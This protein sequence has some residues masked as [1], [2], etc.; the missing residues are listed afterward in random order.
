[1]S[2]GFSLIIYTLLLFLLIFSS[3]ERNDYE[4]FD[5]DTAGTWTLYTTKDGLPSNSAGDI[6]LDRKGNLWVSFPGYGIAKYDYQSWHVYRSTTS[7]LINDI[8]N[9]LTVSADGN[10]IFGTLDGVS[11]L[12]AEGVW[13]SCVDPV[14]TMDVT[15][16]KV[17]KNG[18]IWIGTRDKG[19]YVNTGTG[20]TNN[21][22]AG[23]ERVRAI[24]EGTSGA[25]YIGTENGLVKWQNNVYSYIKKTDGLPDDLITS[26]KFDSK[27]RLWVGTEAGKNVVWFDTGGTLHKV[28]LMTGS[29]SVRIRDI[30]EDRRGH[31]WFATSRNGLIKYDGVVPR[32]FREYNGFPENSVTCIGEDKFGNLWIGLKSKG[33]VK[34]VLPIE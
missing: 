17:A 6:S 16:V 12:S 27:Q 5:P 11:V 19:F 20:Y 30:F 7:P 25:I 26:L 10:I 14:N 31:I 29:D 4:L 21:I 9:C 15:A 28:N 34:Y 18:W 24:E 8:V 3:C 2:K 13:T 1:M 23:Y 32:S 33:L 22:I